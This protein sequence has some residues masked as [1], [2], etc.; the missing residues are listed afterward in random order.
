MHPC[1]YFV[2]RWLEDRIQ[3]SPF[4][5]LGPECE[6]TQDSEPELPSR[7]ERKTRR[8]FLSFGRATKTDRGSRAENDG[9]SDHGLE[10]DSF[11]RATHARSTRDSRSKRTE[12]DSNQKSSKSHKRNKSNKSGKSSKSNR[13]HHKGD[14]FEVMT[15]AMR[16]TECGCPHPFAHLL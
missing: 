4:I 5:Q 7:E 16:R 12:A 13:K 2:K 9:V 15:H 1:C 8:G 11:T 3:I 6:H 10:F 14:E